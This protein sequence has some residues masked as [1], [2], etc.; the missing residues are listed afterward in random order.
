M[1]VEQTQPSNLD[2]IISE[3]LCF[4]IVGK[5]AVYL[6][7]M[8]ADLNSITLSMSGVLLKAVFR[9]FECAT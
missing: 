8:P 3:S 9:N 6:D 5:D 1:P 2:L 4:D 7:A